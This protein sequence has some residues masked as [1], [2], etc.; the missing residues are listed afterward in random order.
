MKR[1]VAAAL[2][3]LSAA[4][5][6]G[7][8]DNGDLTVDGVEVTTCEYDGESYADGDGF[9]A[10]DGCNACICNPMGDTPGEVGCSIMRCDEGAPRVELDSDRGIA[11]AK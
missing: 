10:R 7:C 5:A 4:F 9:A 3:C 11:V 2:L 6:T 1:I 8:L